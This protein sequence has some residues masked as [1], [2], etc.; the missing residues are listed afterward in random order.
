MNMI[1]L[2]D[3]NFLDACM[4]NRAVA[5]GVLAGLLGVKQCAARECIISSAFLKETM[6]CPHAALLLAKEQHTTRDDP[7][8]GMTM[9][10]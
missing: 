10:P 2:C 7:R 5:F 1:F 3:P 4:R 6:I 9:R 8:T